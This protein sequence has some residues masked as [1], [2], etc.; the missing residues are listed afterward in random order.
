MRDLEL[1]LILEMRKLNYKIRI[2]QQEKIPYMV[3]LGDKEEK[4]NVISVR[5]RKGKVI[6]NIKIEEFISKIK[7]E[8]QPEYLLNESSQL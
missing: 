7:I 8:N 4:D 1:K 5:T 6:N 3:I 2:A